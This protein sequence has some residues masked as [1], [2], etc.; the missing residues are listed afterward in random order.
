MVFSADDVSDQLNELLLK[1]L[2]NYAKSLSLNV[3]ILDKDQKKGKSFGSGM[4]ENFIRSYYTVQ[5]RGNIFFIESAI[6]EKIISPIFQI[7]SI[8][9]SIHL[10]QQI[11]KPVNGAVR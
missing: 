4:L 6:H 11:K 9:I 1:R 5:G 8:L 7:R 10:F 3:Q 2:T